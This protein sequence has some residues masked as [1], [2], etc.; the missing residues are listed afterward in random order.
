[1]QILDIKIS[2][3]KAIVIQIILLKVYVVKDFILNIMWL[4]R[5]R[6][7]E[8]EYVTISFTNMKNQTPIS[9]NYGNPDQ[10]LFMCNYPKNIQYERF[11]AETNVFI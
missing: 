8:N 10:Y 11:N 3:F 9:L 1:M 4:Y 6:G 7:A 2:I 5:S